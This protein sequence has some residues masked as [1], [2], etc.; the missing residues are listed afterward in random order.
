MRAAEKASW[1]I[2]AIL[3]L[4]GFLRLYGLGSESVW[5]DEAVSV[6]IAKTSLLSII[7]S[8]INNDVHPPLYYLLLHFWMLLFGQSEAAIRSLSACF[9]IISVYLLYKVGRELF[10]HKVGLVASFLLAISAFAIYYSQEAR[11]Y[12]LLL[13]L[14]LLSFFF[15]IKI[16]GAD[17]PRKT[18]IFFYSL[19]NIL[20]CYTHIFG[21][22]AIGS[23]VLYFLLFR[24]R[25]AKAQLAF[26]T[27][28]TV[29]L[30]SFSPWIFVLVT[31]TF[32]ETVHTLDWIPEPSVILVAR[33]LGALAGA[34]F[35]RLPL[36]AFLMLV[37]LF[38]CL[39]GVFYFTKAAKQK[40]SEQPLPRAKLMSLVTSVAEPR[41][42]L[43]LMWFFF[44]FVMSLTLSLTVRPIFV[45][46]YLIG[47]TPAL[48][49][50]AAR[51][52]NNI[53]SSAKT[54][55]VRAFTNHFS[56]PC[57]PQSWGI[58]R[59]GDTPRSPRQRGLAPLNSPVNKRPHIARA[60]LV[61]AAIVVLVS[62]VSLPGLYTLYAQ[63]QK[64]DWR[65]VVSFVQQEAKPDD[66]VV[67]YPDYHS[68]TFDYYYKGDPKIS[69]IAS[70]VI[71]DE[72]SLL[73]KER[74]WLVLPGYESNEDTSIKQELL[75]RY[76]SD[77]LM[78]QKE[79]SNVT[80]Y[81]FDI[82]AENGQTNEIQ[83]Q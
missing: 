25:Y 29:T 24:S 5:L 61:T 1:L 79:F 37:F 26:W 56:T 63:P 6:H 75:D 3:T 78:L 21:L 39:A 8:G 81:L 67:F 28:Q 54:D 36:G 49:L 20:L 60:N 27:A 34:G 30:V 57:F 73:G 40:D 33:T 46:R 69:V 14:T 70:E 66:I 58:L 10:D 35:L 44:P 22:F 16:L 80:V 4:A 51:G 68:I 47:V 12:S 45:S 53:S 52:I 55:I 72:E 50:L 31:S 65:E 76:G 19:A 43:L 23:Q 7:Q 77:S 32:R 71:E 82:E 11:Q 48:Y 74:L 64:G 17:K 2:L 9:G 42:A 83:K 13:L 15:F 62:L 59:L 18:Y 38:L 41:T